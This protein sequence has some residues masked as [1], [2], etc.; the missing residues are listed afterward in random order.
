[1]FRVV[2]TLPLR[3]FDGRPE[4]SR[5]MLNPLVP[6]GVNRIISNAIA[7]GH[8]SQVVAGAAALAGIKVHSLCCWC[9]E[10]VE[11]EVLRLPAG[12]E[13]DRCPYVGRDCLVVVPNS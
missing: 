1:M 12:G 4:V 2:L 9:A 6:I 3:I 13:C 10:K 8:T 11:G 7:L 5:N